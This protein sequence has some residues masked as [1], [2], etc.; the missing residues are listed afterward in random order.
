MGLQMD[1]T[2]EKLTLSKIKASRDE[3]DLHLDVVYDYQN[4]S[5]AYT[6]SSYLS[7]HDLFTVMGID[8]HHLEGITFSD[9]YPTS[10]FSGRYA[11]DVGDDYEYIFRSKIATAAWKNMTV[12]ACEVDI[13]GDAEK[14]RVVSAQANWLEGKISG[15]GVIE[16]RRGTLAPL[17]KGEWQLANIHLHK[18]LYEKSD[19]KRERI[20]NAT[21]RL[22]YDLDAGIV[23]SGA[24]RADL[25]L[26]GVQLSELPFLSGLNELISDIWPAWGLF[27]SMN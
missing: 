23:A 5:M 13:E 7:Y 18:G 20:L 21:G 25:S 8:T 12:H 11:L 9:E 10:S 26:K 24:G 1:Y 14:M 4:Q 22:S 15:V 6:G 17:F 27:S 19:K 3:A 16:K 2:E